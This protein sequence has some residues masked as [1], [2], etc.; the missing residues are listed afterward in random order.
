MI[1]LPLRPIHEAAVSAL[2]D[3]CFDPARRQRT[4]ALLR[5]GAPRLDV[6]SFVALEGARLVGAVQCHMLMWT[7]LLHPA[8]RII[9]LGPLVSHP[10]WRSRGIGIAL[11]D[12]AVAA[13]DRL[14][15]AMFL[16]GDQPY[17]GRWDFSAEATGQWILPGPVDR[18]RL[19]LRAASPQDWDLPAHIGPLVTASRLEALAPDA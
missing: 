13:V 3:A 7:P 14:G 9:Q 8:R 16:I 15:E 5:K 18:A 1:I 11:M 17:Y 6:A 10:D 2:V 12:S 19:L 4:A